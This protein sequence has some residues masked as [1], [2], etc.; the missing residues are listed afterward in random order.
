MK[1]YKEIDKKAIKILLNTFKKAQ[2]EDLLNWHQWDNYIKHVSTEDFNYAKQQQVMFEREQIS[3]NDICRRICQA[4]S[5]IEKE[6]V[7]NAFIYSLSSRRLEYRSFL[8]SYCIGRH[9]QTHEFT[10]CLN[11]N[12]TICAVCGLHTFESKKLIDFNVENYF[13]YKHGSC[14]D[15]LIAILF[16]LE[17]FLKLPKVKPNNKDHDILNSIK[18]IIEKA[19]PN[20]RVTQLKKQIA[21]TLKSN[22]TER[23]GILETLGIIGVLHDN[24][25]SGYTDNYVTYAEREYRPIR[26]DEVHYPANWW[27]G[28]FGVDS[29][30]WSYW[31]E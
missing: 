13:K 18:N 10:P 1:T 15:N 14:S 16:D 12:E 11:P 20:D 2:N 21:S 6:E 29:K 19:E 17:Q 28:K 7:V 22:D 5:Q 3:H 24:K 25:H 30:Y 26:Y 9:L 8:S 31:F 4:I 27:Q 23:I